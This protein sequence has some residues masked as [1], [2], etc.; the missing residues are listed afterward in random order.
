MLNPPNAT[1]RAKIASVV[2]AATR[3]K[4]EPEPTKFVWNLRSYMFAVDGHIDDALAAL[5]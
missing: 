5:E 1:P 4:P 3:R 2:F